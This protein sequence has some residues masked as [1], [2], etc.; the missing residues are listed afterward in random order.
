MTNPLWD[1]ADFPQL[2]AGDLLGESHHR[3]DLCGSYLFG[4]RY[5][6]TALPEDPATNPDEITLEVCE[7]CFWEIFE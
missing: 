6:V 3:C 2:I 5:A 1:N 7:D 4:N